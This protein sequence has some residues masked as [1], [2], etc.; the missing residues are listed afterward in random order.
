MNKIVK[1]AH[2]WIILNASLAQVISVYLKEIVLNAT[3][4]IVLTVLK[5]IKTA[6][7]ARMDMVEIPL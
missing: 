2:N 3:I 7:Y 6:P 4:K 1:N 5:I